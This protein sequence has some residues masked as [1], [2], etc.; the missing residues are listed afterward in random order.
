MKLRGTGQN[1]ICRKLL[2][3]HVLHPFCFSSPRER[4]SRKE[5]EEGRLDPRATT[6]ASDRGEILLIAW[7]MPDC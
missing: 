7:L 1:K 5:E 3:V 6:S 2:Y 4:G